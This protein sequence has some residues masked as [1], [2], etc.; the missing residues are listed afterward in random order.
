MHPHEHE[1]D[2]IN[3]ALA[4]S[5]RVGLTVVGHVAERAARAREQDARRGQAA[6]EQ[7]ARELQARLDAERAAA[8]AAPR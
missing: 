2:G 8:R 5:L 3:D 4:G 6:S 7:E 1:P